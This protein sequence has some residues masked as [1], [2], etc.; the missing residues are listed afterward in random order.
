MVMG[1]QLTGGSGGWDRGRGPEEGGAGAWWRVA[2]AAAGRPS[3]CHSCRGST[4][5]LARG[6]ASQPTTVAVLPADPGKAAQ[7]HATR[8]LS[9]P[10]NPHA[11]APAHLLNPR[12]VVPRVGAAALVGEHADE[13]VLAC[14]TAGTWKFV[15]ANPSAPQQALCCG[16]L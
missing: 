3:R 7:P 1:G 4:G 5:G 11:L 14:T 16:K 12:H 13:V 6:E 2:A 8:Q 9:A 10:S 15:V